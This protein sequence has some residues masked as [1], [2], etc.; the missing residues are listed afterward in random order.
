MRYSKFLILALACSTLASCYDDKG[1]YSYSDIDEIT[2]TGLPEEPLTAIY[3]SDYLTVTPTVTSK[4]EGVISADDPNYE[5]GYYYNVH[6][7]SEYLSPTLL[8]E[9]KTKDLNILATIPPKPSYKVWFKVTDRRTNITTTAEFEMSVVT[10]MTYGW[11][12]LCEEGADRKVRVDMLAEVGDKVIH[13]KDIMSFLPESHGAISLYVESTASNYYSTRPTFANV[14]TEEGSFFVPYS[15][16]K[17]VYDEASYGDPRTLWFVRAEPSTISR[18][19]RDGL[20]EI[21]VTT[22]GDMFAKSYVYNTVFQFKANTDVV[23]EEPTFKVSQFIGMTRKSGSYRATVY[24]ETN[25]KF[26]YAVGYPYTSLGNTSGMRLYDFTEPTPEAK[27]FDWQIG[28]DL[29]YMQ[30]TN[31]RTTYPVYALMKDNAGRLNIYGIDNGYYNLPT[32]KQS[33]KDENV[34]A[35]GLASAKYFAIHPTLPYLFYNYGN[36]IYVYNMQAK[37]ARKCVTLGSNEEVTMM[38][39]NIANG[40]GPRQD[41]SLATEEL[42]AVGT[43]TSNGEPGSEGIF[44]LFVVPEFIDGELV[45]SGDTHTGLG[46]IKDVGYKDR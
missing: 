22:D 25:K 37:T 19:Y 4:F 10:S 21:F 9:A 35:E 34:Q 8:D 31:V 29:I 43:K 40:D 17:G 7:G 16:S 15:E 23:Y 46:V 14:Y 28:Q 24:D 3:Q 13:N 20:A 44:R 12:I 32:H 11:V 30:G 45:Q 6:D 1:N 33:F 18:Q 38:K 27:L 26:K 42:L 41:R 5:F 39:F 2:I 36:A